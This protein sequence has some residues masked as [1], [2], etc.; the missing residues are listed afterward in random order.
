[1]KGERDMKKIMSFL[2]FAACIIGVHLL[3]AIEAGFMPLNFIS[4]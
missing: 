4:C 3:L 1:M 2:T